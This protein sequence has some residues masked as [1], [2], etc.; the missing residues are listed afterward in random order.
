MV[1]RMDS[2]S[3]TEEGRGEV[4]VRV[5]SDASTVMITRVCIPVQWRTSI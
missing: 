1:V 3:D 2:V 5:D 4:G